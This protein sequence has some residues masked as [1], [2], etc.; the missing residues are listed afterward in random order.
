MTCGNPLAVAAENN[1][2]IELHGMKKH[3]KDR[4]RF[5]EYGCSS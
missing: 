1:P 4:F 2:S 5:P 3:V